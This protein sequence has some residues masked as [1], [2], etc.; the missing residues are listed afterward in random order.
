MYNSNYIDGL[1][2]VDITKIA[3]PGDEYLEQTPAAPDHQGLREVAC[4][5]VDPFRDDMGEFPNGRTAWGG[6][7]SNYPY[8]GS[9]VI[10]V[11]SFDGLFL[12][13]PRIGINAANPAAAGKASPAGNAGGN[14]STG[15]LPD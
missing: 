10:A 14:S 12:V 5:D 1:R 6:A 9:G 2:I 8:F 13:K 7:W 11:S 3:H 15:C 4:F